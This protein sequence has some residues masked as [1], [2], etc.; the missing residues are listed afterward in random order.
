MHARL[1]SGGCVPAS[2]ARTVC[3]SH[4]EGK[5]PLSQQHLWDEVF[6]PFGGGRGIGTHA[7]GPAF[8]SPN[9]PA[10]RLAQVFPIVLALPILRGAVRVFAMKSEV[11]PLREPCVTQVTGMRLVSRV[12]A[13][14]DGQG[15]ALREPRVAQVTGIRLVPRVRAPVGCQAAPHR[16]PC[17]AQVT[18]VRF[19]ARVYTPVAFH[20]P[21]L[22]EPRVAHVTGK[23]KVGPGLLPPPPLY[24]RFGCCCA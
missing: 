2:P 5:N 20:G 17:V 11:S 21:T 4:E 7:I 9:P 15:A 16:E 24:R 3:G 18:G 8:G 23:R 6:R 10:T 19:L 14:V 13:D 12:R 22:R 1:C